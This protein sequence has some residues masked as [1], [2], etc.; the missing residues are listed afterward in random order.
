MH[1]LRQLAL[2]LKA[3]Q[4]GLSNCVEWDE[5]AA[6]RVRGDPDLYGLTPTAIKKELLDFVGGGE[7]RQVK[8]TRE[9][10][11][12]LYDFY[13]KAIIPLDGFPHGLFVEIRLSDDDEDYP[14]VLLVNAHVQT[15]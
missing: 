7:V 1:D 11:K 15:P 2:L 10:W 14:E 8:E 9:R 3:L 4:S 6:R 5:K 12:D 13:Y